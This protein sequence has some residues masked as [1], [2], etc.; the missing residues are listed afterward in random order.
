[1]NDGP[2]RIIPVENCDFERFVIIDDRLDRYWGGDSWTFLRSSATVFSNIEHAMRRVLSL[3]SGKELRVFSVPMIIH[4]ESENADEITMEQL[5]EFLAI[6]TIH[7]VIEDDVGQI[8]HD[9]S[10]TFSMLWEDLEEWG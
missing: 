6:K 4:L 8:M 9:K 1:M 2:I 5:R 7:W 10:V 3:M